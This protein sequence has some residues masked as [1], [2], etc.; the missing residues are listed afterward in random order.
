[1][2]FMVTERQKK[3]SSRKR[4]QYDENTVRQCILNVKNGKQ[5][6]YGASKSFGVPESTIRFRLS[7]KWSKKARKGPQTVMSKY[8]EEKIVV[9]LK[10][11]QRKGFPVVKETLFSKIKTFF[12]TTSRP[13]PF[14]NNAPGRIWFNSFLQ[15]HKSFSLRTPEAVSTAS[16]NVSECNI[17]SWFTNVD[18]YLE[19]RNQSGILLDPSRVYNGDET[20]FFLHP[21]TKAVLAARGSRNVYEVE[22]ANIHT[23][24]TVMFSFAADGSIVPSN[25]ILPMQRIRADLLRTFPADWGIGKSAKGWMD[26]PN[27]ELYIQKVFYPFLLKKGVTFPVLYFVDGHSFHMAVD[28]ADL[29]LDLGIILIV[30]YPNTTQITQPADVAIF[31]PLKNAWKA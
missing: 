30:L 6:I 20:S 27:F 3:K 12:D 13:N 9:W 23:N 26:A 22:H 10:E 24:I 18:S 1:M 28:V 14:P 4:R 5:T 19:E 17:R 15:R 21:K 7:D 31:K 11:M 16:A 25:I 29:C 8:E 2:C